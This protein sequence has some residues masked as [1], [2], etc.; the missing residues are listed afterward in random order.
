MELAAAQHRQKEAEIQLVTLQGELKETR[1]KLA[2]LTEA[3]DKSEVHA[4]EELKRSSGKS[5]NS[6]SKEGTNR[7]RV[8]GLYRLGGEKV[9]SKSQNQV[10]KNII[11][12]NF[13]IDCKGVA[14]HSL[15]NVT[16]EDQDGADDQSNESRRVITSERSR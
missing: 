11:A 8:R 14:R 15:R 5:I 16:N 1:Q 13:I 2:N 9:E 12:D 3:Q 10:I 4:R 7:G 6:E